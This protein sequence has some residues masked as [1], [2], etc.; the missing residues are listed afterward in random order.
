MRPSRLQRAWDATCR[1]VAAC[2][3]G[4]QAGLRSAISGIRAF[5][6]QAWAFCTGG[7]ARTPQAEVPASAPRL[8]QERAAQKPTP[9]PDADGDVFYDVD[10]ALWDV[11]KNG[12][13]PG[14]APARD[15]ALT[16]AQRS[17]PTDAAGR[18]VA[19][20]IPVATL[21]DLD[22][23]IP[24]T[25]IQPLAFNQSQ[26]IDAPLDDLVAV[27]M[28]RAGVR[29]WVHGCVESESL[30]SPRPGCERGYMHVQKLGIIHVDTATDSQLMRVPP[31]LVQGARAAMVKVSEVADFQ[32]PTRYSRLVSVRGRFVLRAVSPAQTHVSY[33]VVVDGGKSKI[34]SWIKIKVGGDQ[35]KQTLD[36]LRKQVKRGVAEPMRA[37]V[38]ALLA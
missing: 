33:E 4:I 15:A 19:G 14:S 32:R 20:G 6:V 18:S 2:F 13:T 28:D 5:C 26:M 17:A 7:S 16:S 3:Q 34:P 37:N 35:A 21:E 11:L 23:P 22:T 29:S 36:G 31:E 27:L 9:A 30:G 1:G 8:G 10:D 24:V 12:G 25:G 38:S